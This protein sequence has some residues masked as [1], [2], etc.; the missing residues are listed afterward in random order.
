MLPIIGDTTALKHIKCHKKHHKQNRATRVL[1]D[2]D[3]AAINEGS[4]LLPQ[5]SEKLVL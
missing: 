1:A 4:S 3:A 2:L 5:K